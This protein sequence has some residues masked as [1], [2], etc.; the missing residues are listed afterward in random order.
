MRDL[1]QDAVDRYARTCELAQSLREKWEELGCPLLAEGGATGK[2]P[3]VHPLIPAMQAAERDAARY[4][5]AAGY[6][7]DK[8]RRLSV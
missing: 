4:E 2:A 8:L 5:R 7:G 3:V 1:D 6:A